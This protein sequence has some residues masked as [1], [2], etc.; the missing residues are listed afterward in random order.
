MAAGSRGSSARGGC[1]RLCARRALLARRVEIVVAVPA[2]RMIDVRLS[3]RVDRNA[4]PLDVGAKPA[5]KAGRLLDKRAQPF[6]LGRVATD[7]EQEEVEAEREV[8]DLALRGLHLCP[9][10]TLDHLRGRDRR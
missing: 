7:I 3:P 2:R 9:A 5:G 4:A 1:C 10:E 8:L 6:L